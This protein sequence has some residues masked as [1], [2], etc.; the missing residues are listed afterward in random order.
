MVGEDILNWR[1][2]RRMKTTG[3][4]SEHLRNG[5]SISTPL[6]FSPF[7]RRW[8]AIARFPF[9]KMRQE[10]GRFLGKISES[11]P[12]C[13]LTSRTCESRCGAPVPRATVDT[14]YPESDQLATGPGDGGLLAPVPGRSPV[15]AAA[16]VIKATWYPAGVSTS[17]HSWSIFAD[18][19]Q[20]SRCANF[21]YCLAARQENQHLLLWK[22]SRRRR[23]C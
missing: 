6:S 18:S 20:F 7:L 12:A 2:T 15:P 3:R 10:R 8:I 1:T 11:P 14:L 16:D 22:G 13:I 4:T 5:S 19:R 9:V 21:W 17:R 23:Y